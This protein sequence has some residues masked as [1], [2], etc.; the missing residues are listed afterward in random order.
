MLADKITAELERI[1]AG[2]PEKY[3][4]LVAD[5]FRN[6]VPLQEQI[7]EGLKHNILSLEREKAYGRSKESCD[8]WSIDEIG[9]ES[10]IELKLCPTNYCQ[11]FSDS[12]K[13]IGITQQIGHVIL[14]C[15]KLRKIEPH[16]ER[17]IVL[18]AYPMPVG[19]EHPYWRQHANWILEHA[20][21]M[22]RQLQFVL[23][24]NGTEAAIN[25]YIIDV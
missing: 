15:G 6:E 22:F 2:E 13:S 23:R 5:R 16:H 17:K 25:V 9:V 7:F 3:T 12:K 24:R 1:F 11:Y 4:K 8:F 18:L 14:D 20:N 10:W 19:E 21:N